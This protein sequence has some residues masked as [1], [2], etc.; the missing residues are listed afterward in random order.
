[1]KRLSLAAATAAIALTTALPAVAQFRN[2]EAAIKYRQSVMVVQQHHLGRIF[3]MANGRI[4]FDASVAAADAAVLDTIDKLPF[5]AFIDGSDKGDTRA[6]PA[7][8]TERAKFDAA[9]Q[10][11]IDDVSKLNVAA[12]TG[13]LDQIKAAVGAAAQSCKACHDNYRK[14]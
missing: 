2:A 6:L 7:I 12:K 5:V 10:K 11:M 14:E 9:A 3:A 1:M 4:P 13:N 8:W